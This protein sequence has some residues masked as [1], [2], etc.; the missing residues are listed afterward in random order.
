MGSLFIVFAVA[1][2]AATFIENDYGSPA[3]YSMVYGSKWFELVLLLLA[4]NLAGQVLIFKLLRKKNYN[5]II[6]PVLHSYPYRSR[7]NEVFRMGRDYAH[8]GR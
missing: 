7:Y 5:S 4:L 8:K 1:M 2:A 6:P 3:A